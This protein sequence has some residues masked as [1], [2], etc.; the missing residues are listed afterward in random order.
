MVCFRY[1]LVSTLYKGEKTNNN[2]NIL[3]TE[4]Q[5]PPHSRLWYTVRLL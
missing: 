1:I 3:P 2:N 4:L 5:L